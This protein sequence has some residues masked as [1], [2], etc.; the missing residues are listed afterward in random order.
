MQVAIALCMFFCTIISIIIGIVGIVMTASVLGQLSDNDSDAEAARI[1]VHALKSWDTPMG[2]A[3]E[4]R[5][6]DEGC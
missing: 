3:I 2:T 1:I 4:V 5:D 6:N